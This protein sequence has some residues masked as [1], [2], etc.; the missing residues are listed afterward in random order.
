MVTRLKSRQ[1]SRQ[2]ERAKLHLTTVSRQRLERL[3]KWANQSLVENGKQV[4]ALTPVVTDQLEVLQT[5]AD[6]EAQ[7]LREKKRASLMGLGRFVPGNPAKK[8][9]E[10][11]ERQKTEL[12]SPLV[13]LRKDA[14]LDQET[15]RSLDWLETAAKVPEKAK[16]AF[17]FVAQR[18]ANWDYDSV[19]GLALIHAVGGQ[20][21]ANAA[22]DSVIAN[23]QLSWRKHAASTVA[24][25]QAIGGERGPSSTDFAVS[26][27]GLR[28]DTA[29]ATVALVHALAGDEKARAAMNFAVASSKSALGS[30]RALTVANLALAHVLSGGEKEADAALTFAVAKGYRTLSLNQE[31]L[32]LLAQAHALGGPEKTQA[33]LDFA[34]QYRRSRGISLKD[35]AL[36]T[37]VLAHVLGGE[38]LAQAGLDFAKT[39]AAQWADDASALVT[40]AF[41]LSGEDAA[42]SAFSFAS[43]V[44]RSSRTGSSWG[45][46]AV[47]GLMLSSV[48]AGENPNW[49]RSREELAAVATSVMN[50]I[51]D[52]RDLMRQ[53]QDDER[54]QA[55][56]QH[57]SG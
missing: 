5:R 21:K 25:A 38:E 44:A 36:A 13:S 12:Q 1:L 43:T 34:V 54:R 39:N 16:G 31:A 51:R 3:Q 47:A 15:V 56:E 26:N 24:L 20:A 49:P 17:D 37:I 52:E 40:L 53:A 22:L 11:L 10:T 28:S 23:R 41:A 2:A 18:G 9:F 42:R 6:A 33:A 7:L 45:S 4:N 19:G 57:R 32:A 50:G 55:E 48:L 35:Q 14:A 46:Q 8:I 30:V 29:I 27:S